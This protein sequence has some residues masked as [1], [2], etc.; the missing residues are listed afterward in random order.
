MIRAPARISETARQDRL[1][2]GSSVQDLVSSGRV[3]LRQTFE[4]AHHPSLGSPLLARFLSGK[5]VWIL[6]SEAVGQRR[7][8]GLALS[9]KVVWTH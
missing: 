1:T 2:L 7:L 4:A 5:A 9:G 3:V 6:I 8:R